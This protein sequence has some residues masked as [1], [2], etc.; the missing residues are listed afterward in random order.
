VTIPTCT[1]P[2]IGSDFGGRSNQRVAT[3]SRRYAGLE[4]DFNF[5]WQKAPFAPCTS[6][7]STAYCV[8]TCRWDAFRFAH[9]TVLSL[10]SATLQRK[11]PPRIAAD[12]FWAKQVTLNKAPWLT[13]PV[14]RGLD[15]LSTGG[16]F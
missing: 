14:K 8:E 10:L 1:G 7:E 12:G 3:I 4:E 5:G 9:P 16:P 6:A 13:G 11:N 15:Y 2:V